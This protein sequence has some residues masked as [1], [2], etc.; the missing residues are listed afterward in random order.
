[1]K[2][3]VRKMNRLVIYSLDRDRKV[4]GTGMSSRVSK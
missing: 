1:M 3:M 4:W 2:A